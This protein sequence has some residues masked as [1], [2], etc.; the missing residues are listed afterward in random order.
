MLVARSVVGEREGKALTLVL[1]RGWR[2]LSCCLGVLDSGGGGTWAG[3]GGGAEGTLGCLFAVS[4]RS[5]GDA[6]ASGAA[7]GLPDRSVEAGRDG[8][9]A[10]AG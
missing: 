6:G 7:V 9:P 10:G 3:T 5:G 2:L 1:G 4:G 8:C